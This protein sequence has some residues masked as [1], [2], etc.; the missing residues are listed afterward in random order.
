MQNVGRYLKKKNKD[1]E[2]N[3]VDKRN[4]SHV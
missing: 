3:A 1:V 4:F 2:I